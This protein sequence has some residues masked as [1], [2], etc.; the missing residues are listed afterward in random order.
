MPRHFSGR[1][2]RQARKASGRSDAELAIALGKSVQLVHLVE[3][4]HRIPSVR[5]LDEWCQIL[6]VPIDFCFVDDDEPVAVQ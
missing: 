4:G 2:L 1:K 3:S 5:V 6:G